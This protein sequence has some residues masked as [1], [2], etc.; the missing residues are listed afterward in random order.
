MIEI[1]HGLNE[2]SISGETT[3]EEIL[4]MGDALEFDRSAVEVSVN[5]TVRQSGKIYDGDTV[6]VQN[7]RHSKASVEIKFGLS[8]IKSDTVDT[9]D[10]VLSLGPSMEFDP[11]NVEVSVNGTV[12]SSGRIEDGDTVV[13]QNRRHTKAWIIR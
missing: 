12:R 7:K 11:D 2:S 6:V 8:T 10:K 4:A 5:G 3:V 1:Q 9:I 13:V